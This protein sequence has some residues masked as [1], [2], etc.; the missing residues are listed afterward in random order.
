HCWH[1]CFAGQC[2]A[3]ARISVRARRP[4]R[5]EKEF[6]DT[7]EI[8]LARLEDYYCAL[9]D[10]IRSEERSLFGHL[11]KLPQVLAKHPTARAVASLQIDNLDRMVQT[12]KQNVDT[13][14]AKVSLAETEIG[15]F[16]SFEEV[17]IRSR[18]T[19]QRGIRLSGYRFGTK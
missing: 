1:Q 18:L 6:D 4:S 7:V 11:T 2:T 12:V 3:A 8:L 14:E 13:L 10:L 9:I 17:F 16:T 15:Q 5:Q 19:K